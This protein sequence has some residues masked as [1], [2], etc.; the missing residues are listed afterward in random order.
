MLI[1]QEYKAIIDALNGLEDTLQTLE[2]YP[3]PH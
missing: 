1:L 2:T 3:F